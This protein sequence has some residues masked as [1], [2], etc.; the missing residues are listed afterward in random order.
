MMR[1]L[2]KN[3][4]VWILVGLLVVFVIILLI[5][6]QQCSRDGEM[7]KGTKPAKIETDF[8]QSYAA[9]SDLKL[10]G[11]LCQ[12]AYVKELRQVETDFNAIYKRA[13]AANVWDGLSEADQ[14][15][16]TAYGDVGTKL[17]VMNTAIEKQDYPKAKR[18]LAEI[19]EVE[20]GV[21]QGITK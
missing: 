2:L 5:A 17:G 6:L 15:I 12:A 1:E 20:K 4:K 3:K 21:K 14:R 11:D 10:N 16:Y 19:L 7:D 13:K 18:L 8:R 9:W